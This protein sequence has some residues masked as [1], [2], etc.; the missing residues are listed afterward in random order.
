MDIARYIDHTLLSPDCTISRIE[1]ICNEAIEHGFAAVCVPP[2]YVKTASELLHNN[3]ISIAT[4]IGFPM[5]YS[6]TATK[7]AELEEAI[8]AGANELDVVHNISMVKNGDYQSATEEI[9]KLT[10]AV[11]SNGKTIKVILETSSLF[12]EEILECCKHYST[13]GVHYIKTSSGF[14]GE[15]ASVVVVELLRKNLPV[16]IKIKASG[17]I[18][19]FAKAKALIDAGADRLGCSKSIDIINGSLQE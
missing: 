1:Q 19:T 13:V 10:D 7:L 12:K 6:T 18:R 4:V 17:G 3:G 11:I 15:G 14:N 16:D 2:C 5:G 9:Q 8:T